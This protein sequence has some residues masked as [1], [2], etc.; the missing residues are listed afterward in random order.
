METDDDLPISALS[1]VTYCPR[2]AA[3]VHVLGHWEENQH[4]AAGQLAHQR[5]DDGERSTA[6]DLQ[7]LRSVSV[8][9]SRLRLRGVVDA[10]EIRSPPREPRYLVVET[11]RGK[12]K[13]WLRDEI[14]LC[15]Q[16]MALEEM[17]GE[18]L[19]VGVIFYAASKRRRSVDLTD[20]L[21]S[22]TEAA[23]ARLHQLI[24]SREI[25]PPVNDE[26][27]EDCSLQGPCQP[28]GRARLLAQ[29]IERAFE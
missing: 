10:L 8:W 12:R 25:P 14:Q 22:D 1:H 21:R 26:R 2:R 5:V 4:T 19:A 18:K 6:G 16:S 15:A 9:S 29:A 28:R 7:V 20:T 23:A 11:K 27:C 3:L 17:T 13:R 24:R